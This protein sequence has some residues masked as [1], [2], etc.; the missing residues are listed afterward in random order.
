MQGLYTAGAFH[1]FSIRHWSRRSTSQSVSSVCVCV[2]VC[3]CTGMASKLRTKC[4]V[5]TKR[6]RTFV[7]ILRHFNVLGCLTSYPCLSVC[8]YC[9]KQHPRLASVHVFGQELFYRSK[10]SFNVRD[11][12]LVVVLVVD[13]CSSHAHGL[14]SVLILDTHRQTYTLNCCHHTSD[15]ASRQRLRSSSRHHLV[16][17]R[18]RRSTLGRRAFSVAGPMA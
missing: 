8:T 1:N 12:L 5:K 16:V 17:P 15:V 18:H 14:Q 3:V 2:C 7:Y 11:Q 10:K 9:N 4:T 13:R 6:S